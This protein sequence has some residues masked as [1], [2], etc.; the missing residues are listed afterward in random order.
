MKHHVNGFLV[1]I[2]KYT[3]KAGPILTFLE[4]LNPYQERLWKIKAVYLKMLP[5]SYQIRHCPGFSWDRVD[6][7]HS[8]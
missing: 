6:F 7:L 4:V 2:S 1:K 3:Q 8:M 5:R